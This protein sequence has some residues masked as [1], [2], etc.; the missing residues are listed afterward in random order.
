[1]KW[2]VLNAESVGDPRGGFV[3]YPSQICI[4]TNPK[5]KHL[6]SAQEL[7]VLQ[8]ADENVTLRAERD[9]AVRL[10]RE[11]D[12]INETSNGEGYGAWSVNSETQE[13]L[14]NFLAKVKP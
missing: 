2:F 8:Q 12:V 9:E 3:N 13:R 7:V 1:M 5:F 6:L 14:S 11:L 10:L 4:D